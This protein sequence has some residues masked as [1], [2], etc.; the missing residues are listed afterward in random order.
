MMDEEILLKNLLHKT[1]K[2]I[3]KMKYEGE[4]FDEPEL[5]EIIETL[6]HHI[7]LVHTYFDKSEF[8]A[9]D[10][11]IKLQDKLKHPD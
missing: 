11:R 2:E 1:N 5:K 3:T 7:F 4:F 6:Q 8:T 10:I 9:E